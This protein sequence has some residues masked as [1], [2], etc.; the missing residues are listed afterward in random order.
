MLHLK[1][2]NLLSQLAEKLASDFQQQKVSVFQP[3][4]IVTQT[5]GMNNWLKLQIAKHNK[6]AANC[7]FLKPNDL[8]HNIYFLLGGRQPNLLS[9]GNLT[10]LLYNILGEKD[11]N[12]Q[13]RH[14]ANYYAADSNDRDIK[15]LALAEKV[16]DLFDQYQVYRPDMI[17]QW[18]ATPLNEISKDEW[19]QYLWKKAKELSGDKL[20]DKTVIREHIIEALKVPKQIEKLV[21]QMPVI[22][23]F[24]LSVTTAYHLNIFNFLSEKIEI[25]YYLL[26]PAPNYYWF[27]DKSEK[28]LAVLSKKGLIDKTPSGNGNP[29]L[30]NWGRVISD[31]F[32]LLFQNEDLLNAYEETGVT[33]PKPL[34]LLHKIQQDI[35]QN[36]TSDDRNNLS[37]EDINDGSLTI[38]ACYTIAREVEVLYNYLVHLADSKEVFSP[39]DVVVMVTDIDAYAPYIKAVFG[40]APYKFKFTIADESFSIGDS[41]TNA[42]KSVLSMNRQNFKAE[43]VLQLLDSTFIRKRFGLSDLSLIRKA[44]DKANIRFG[45]EGNKTDDT[46]YVSWS[47][48]LNRI[49][50]GICMSGEDEYDIGDETL[51]PIDISEGGDALELVRFT[52]FIQVLMDSINERKYDRTI[53][54]WVEYTERIMQNLVCETDEE[55]EDEYNLILKELEKLNAVNELLNEKIS[56]DIFTHSFVQSI[57]TSTRAGS[58]AVGGITFCSLIPMRSIPFKIVA[59]LGLNFDKFPRKEIQIGFN[60]MDQKRMK[61]DRNVKDNDKHL[62]LETIMSAQKFLYMSY[63]GQSVKDNTILPPSALLDELIDYIESGCTQKEEIR[64]SLI[65]RHSIHSFSRKYYSGD[66]SFYNYLDDKNTFVKQE[67]NEKKVITKIDFTQI[68]LKQFVSF[69]KHPFK[70][71]YNKVLNIYY[72]EESVLLSDTELFELDHLQ[73]WNLK[74]E[75]LLLNQNESSILQNRLVKSG[76]LPLK[77]MAILAMDEIEESVGA[78]R[79]LFDQCV[80]CAEER[81][82]KIELEIGGSILNGQID[83]VYGNRLV[84]VSYSKNEYKYMLDAYISY[85]V[86]R[87]QN[88]VISVHFISA[89]KQQSFNGAFIT[90]ED[91][92]LKLNE[93]LRLYKQGYESILLFHPL[94]KIEPGKLAS[95]DNEKFAKII[96]Q[97]FE[98]HQVPCNDRYLLKEYQN[99]FFENESSAEN[100]KINCQN[101]LEPLVIFFPEYFNSATK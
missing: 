71:Y 33:E 51:Y 14:I 37:P 97:L 77:N 21:T 4:Y 13:Y 53:S 55:G 74:N 9:S 75:L 58:F 29:L 78:V 45:M 32:G 61:G 39:R 10:W 3:H 80:N 19:Q 66:K 7:I 34:N 82:I 15:R 93:L 87:A 69:F 86:A 60:L 94:L 54:E 57:S 48:G 84:F 22:Y 68:N 92:A 64:V 5:D 83:N 44:V 1:V 72:E 98:N 28:Q 73:K 36:A 70:E 100:F 20:P 96:K 2:S 59:L 43:E 6:I 89:T 17:R 16:T 23:M 76:G 65:R 56:Y 18:N 47:Y 27:D 30:T 12:D 63:I 79:V 52:H 49:M 38:N 91:A 24:G 11:F 46:R 40:N 101:L 8:I 41:I 99:G 67:K 90:K 42:L 26:N 88:E 35:F 50:F 81:S 25:Q 85:L 62:F 95:L 31:T